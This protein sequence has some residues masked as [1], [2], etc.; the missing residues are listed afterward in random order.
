MYTQPWAYARRERLIPP[1]NPAAMLTFLKMSR[2]HAKN[3][4][5]ILNMYKKIARNVLN[6]QKKPVYI[7]ENLLRVC[8]KIKKIAEINVILTKKSSIL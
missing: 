2:K 4:S 1:L 8:T 3:L 6:L 7:F 5:K